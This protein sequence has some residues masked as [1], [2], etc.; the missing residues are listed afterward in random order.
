MEEEIRDFRLSLSEYELF[1]KI[2][3]FENKGFMFLQE[4]Q[5]DFY[6]PNR[7]QLPS[8]KILNEKEKLNVEIENYIK[9]VK[10]QVYYID[11]SQELA[12]EL[13]KSGNKFNKNL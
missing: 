6:V 10:G 2:N 11:D 3:S 7:Y 9:K 5:M 1:K 8:G 4:W 13:T 12:E